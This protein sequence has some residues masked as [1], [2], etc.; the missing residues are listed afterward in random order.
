[1]PGMGC[2]I[3]ETVAD[4]DDVKASEF[5]GVNAAVTVCGPVVSVLLM[6]RATPP[7]TG[8]GAPTG[9]VPSANWTLP[10]APAGPT[11]ARKITGTPWS[12]ER[13]NTVSVVV[14]AVVP[15][16]GVGVGVTGIGVGTTG[17]GVTGPGVG[18]TGTGV[19]VGVTGVGV[20]VTGAGLPVGDGLMT[21]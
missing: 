15:D 13:G 21:V 9:V 16:I 7:N 5:V 19:D 12:A 1:M 17:V 3:S 2:T 14:V 20:G 6:N 11:F 8:T 10:I 18:V 4:V